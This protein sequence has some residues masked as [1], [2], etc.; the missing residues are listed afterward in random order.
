MH[1]PGHVHAA[2]ESTAFLTLLGVLAKVLPAAASFLAVI[3]YSIVIWE[4]PWGK[5]WRQRW[6]NL[7]YGLRT[8]KLTIEDRL[9]LLMLALGGGGFYLALYAVER[10]MQ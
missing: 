5:R 1:I 7:Y 8:R 2:A 6:K 4:S 9:V 10:V 3:W